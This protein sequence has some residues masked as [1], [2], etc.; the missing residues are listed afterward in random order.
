MKLTILGSGGI[1]PIPKPL[2]QC[3][4]CKEARKKGVPYSRTGPSAFLH[5][6][7][8]LIDT[9][10]QISNSINNANIKEIDNLI[11][12]HLD[13]DHFD[14]HSAL[15]SLYFDGT[16]Y[17]YKPKKTINMLVPQK[18]DEKLKTITSQYGNLFDFYTKYK[19]VKKK[20]IKDKIKIK[21]ITIIPIFVKDNPATPY[22]YLFVDEKGKKILYAPCDSKPF[23]LK[24]KYVYDVDLF[25]TQTGFFETGLKEGFVYPQDDYTRIE[26]Y[27]FDQTLDIA[28]KIRTKKVLFMHLEEY[29]NRSHDDYKK[30]EKKYT[31]IR[32]AYDGMTIEV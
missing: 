28:K 13:G 15:I 7:K 16:K 18:I 8:L 4:I 17:C 6:A 19:V 14:G 29:W 12:T 32:F 25:I 20:I 11:Y 1:I 31:N 26:L 21:N 24:S 5:D 10:P 30:L 3:Q 22:I 2:C 9:P 27:S 23:P